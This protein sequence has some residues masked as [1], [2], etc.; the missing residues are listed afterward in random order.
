MW[1]DVSEYDPLD[2]REVPGLKLPDGSSA[3]LYSAYRKGPA[4]LHCKWMRQ[5]GI[6]GVFLSRF[7]STDG[8]G[9]G[10]ERER[11]ND[12]QNYFF[13]KLYALSDLQT[14]KC[15]GKLL[16]NNSVRDLC[17]IIPA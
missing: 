6:D 13:H 11:R 1:P 2:L 15:R 17:D 12:G 4:L 9:C 3:R 5:Y 7:V 8:K 16:V 14:S 10:G